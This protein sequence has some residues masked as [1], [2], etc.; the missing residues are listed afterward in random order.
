MRDLITGD[1]TITAV[2]T[3][4]GD[5]VVILHSLLSDRTAFA[6]VVPQLAERNRVTLINLP[7]FHG[8]QPVASTVEAYVDA[9]DHAIREW[10]LDNNMTLLGNGFGGTL[11]IAFA[12]MKPAQLS[13]LV[14]VDAAAMFPEAGRKAFVAMAGMVRAD[15][16]AAIATVAARRVYHDD[17]IEKHPHVIN[18]RRAVLLGVQPDAFLAAC[19]ILASCDLVPLLPGIE[20]PTLVIYGEKDQATPP[21]L[22]RIIANKIP[23]AREHVI[24]NCGHC[25]PLEHPEAFL[26]ALRGFVAC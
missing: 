4:A 16:M 24:E 5:D 7:G 6:A 23:G 13:R 18:E 9:I 17:Y 14:L 10:G 2:Q 22:N 26:S 15:G 25:P 11:A 19:Q 12:A 3:G 1:S 21:E 20:K 8:S